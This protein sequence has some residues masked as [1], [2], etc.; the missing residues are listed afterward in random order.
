MLSEIRYLFQYCLFFQLWRM[1]GTRDPDICSYGRSAPLLPHRPV[2][3]ASRPTPSQRDG[4]SA[5]WC[6]LAVSKWLF[7][8]PNQT[9][10]LQA[11]ANRLHLFVNLT[12]RGG[13]PIRDSSEWTKPAPSFDAPGSAQTHHNGQRSS[14]QRFQ[15]DP[16]VQAAPT[17][18]YVTCTKPAL[19]GTLLCGWG[20]RA[21]PDTC[22]SPQLPLTSA[23][24]DTAPPALMWHCGSRHKSTGLST[25]F[26]CHLTLS[27]A[28]GVIRCQ[29]ASSGR[30]IDDF[31][32]TSTTTIFNNHWNGLDVRKSRKPINKPGTVIIEKFM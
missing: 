17:H 6:F 20:P 19:R 14:G 11:P 2:P 31:S 18:S 5:R 32:F 16:V 8:L 13:A 30:L 9:T 27:F 21:E 22:R 26:L 7:A 24:T 23:D 25:T 1:C 12:F 4:G 28:Y 29:R 3:G 15:Q 10:G